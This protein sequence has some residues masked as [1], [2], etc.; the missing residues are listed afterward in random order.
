MKKFKEEQMKDEDY[1]EDD[2]ENLD[3]PETVS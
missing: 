3:D 1:D 2:D